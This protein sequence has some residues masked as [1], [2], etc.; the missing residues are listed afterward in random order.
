MKHSG[1]CSVLPFVV[2][3][4]GLFINS[5]LVY[6]SI[7]NWMPFNLYCSIY[8][9]FLIDQLDRKTINRCCF[10]VATVSG[11]YIYAVKCHLSISL[12]VDGGYMV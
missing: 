2:D 11:S 10:L 7:R 5:F 4:L 6:G 12:E 3:T 9:W 8:I 1:D